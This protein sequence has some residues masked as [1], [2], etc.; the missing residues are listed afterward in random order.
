MLPPWLVAHLG[1]Q[2]LTLACHRQAK[3]DSL[4]PWLRSAI[5][6]AHYIDQFYNCKENVLGEMG[7]EVSPALR[8][9]HPRAVGGPK[10]HLEA[11]VPGALLIYE[12]GD[13][14]GQGVHQELLLYRLSLVAGP[15]TAGHGEGVVAVAQGIVPGRRGAGLQGVIP[16]ALVACTAVVSLALKAKT[17][18]PGR[19]PSRSLRFWPGWCLRRIC[20]F[21]IIVRVFLAGSVQCRC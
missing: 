13:D 6:E 17:A 5:A 10:D 11:A 1:A 21:Q 7:L 2:S 8:A 3:I 19:L 15:V 4:A 18:P 20:A 14:R 16:T 12:G 9:G